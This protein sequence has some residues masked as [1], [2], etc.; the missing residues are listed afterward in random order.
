LLAGVF[1]KLA[2]VCAQTHSKS[3]RPEFC[4]FEPSFL[5]TFCTEE[6]VRTCR[7]PAIGAFALVASVL[8]IRPV[9]FLLIRFVFVR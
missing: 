2:T 8:V 6:Y 5:G 3:V 4:G 9:I 7:F 1:G